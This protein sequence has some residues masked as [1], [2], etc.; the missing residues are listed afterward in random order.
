MNFSRKS[1]FLT[2]LVL[3]VI[4][5]Y[6]PGLSGEFLFD[7]FHSIVLNESVKVREFSFQALYSSAV[8]GFQ[9]GLFGRP[10]SMLSFGLSH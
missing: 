5:A 4:A 2:I 6:L 9:I 10:I 8:S 3:F 7:D 1:F